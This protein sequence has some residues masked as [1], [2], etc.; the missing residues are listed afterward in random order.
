MT[1][2]DMECHF[3]ERSNDPNKV[4]FL[5]PDNKTVNLKGQSMAMGERNVPRAELDSLPDF[6]IAGKEIGFRKEFG[7]LASDESF[8]EV[9]LEVVER[10]QSLLNLELVDSRCQDCARHG[11]V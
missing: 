9:P 11:G 8:C 1:E 7:T 6:I 5:T 10:A 3:G 4:A 2:K